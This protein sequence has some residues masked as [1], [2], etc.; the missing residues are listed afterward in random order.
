MAGNSNSG[1]HL[2]GEKCPGSGRPVGQKN[3]KTLIMDELLANSI[4]AEKIENGTLITPAMF[5]IDILNDKT[6]DENL[7]HECAKSLAPYL[8]KKQ[9]QMTETKITSDL[10]NSEGF[11]IS[12][13]PKNE[14][15]I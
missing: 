14:R 9:P 4:W 6:K 11:T 2:K 7:R 3:Y 13:I 5:W 15:N 8:Y 12:V 10:E 1:Q